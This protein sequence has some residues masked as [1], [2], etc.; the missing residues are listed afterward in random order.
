LSPIAS[1]VCDIPLISLW[2]ICLQV[3]VSD[4]GI[5]AQPGSADI[6]RWMANAGR[7]QHQSILPWFWDLMSED[8]LQR[9]PGMVRAA[10]GS[11]S[12]AGLC[13]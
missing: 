13:C 6:A 12:H 5:M 2:F 7:H 1:N 8:D 10:S 11:S 4:E 9:A 3:K